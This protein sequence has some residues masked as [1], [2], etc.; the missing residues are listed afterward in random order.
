MATP[1]VLMDCGHG[2]INPSTSLYVTPGKRS[3]IWDDGTQYFEGVGNRKIGGY[4]CDILTAQNI[5]WIR[6]NHSWMDNSL[7]SRI[8][9]ANIYKGSAFGI[10]IHSN[11]GGGEGIEVFTSPGDTPADPMA[12]I[13]VEEF[14]KLFPGYKT[15]TDYK[16]GDPDKEEKFAMLTHTNHPWFLPEAFFMDN[17]E[18]CRKI[19]MTESGLRKIAVWHANTIVRIINERYK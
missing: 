14:K 4:V 12:T 17:E 5:K 11:A 10:S 8:D 18:E 3:P 6:L 9:A 1:I 2:G 15:R 16:D 7:Q 13:S 19:L